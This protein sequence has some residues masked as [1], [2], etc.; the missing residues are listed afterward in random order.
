MPPCSRIRQMLSIAVWTRKQSN[1]GPFRWGCMAAE[2]RL[3]FSVYLVGLS[4][5]TTS[6]KGTPFLFPSQPLL[7]AAGRA[8]NL[9]IARFTGGVGRE[10]S[11]LVHAPEALGCILF[12]RRIDSWHPYVRYG[13]YWNRWA[14][15]AIGWRDSRTGVPHAGAA[16]ISPSR[17]N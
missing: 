11:V 7:S 6:G 5:R 17:N 3:A 1:L 14:R 4:S 8:G 12:E 2:R 13:R 9:V 10:S 16:E 15:F